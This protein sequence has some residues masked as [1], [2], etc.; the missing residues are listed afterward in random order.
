MHHRAQVMIMMERARLGDH[1]EGD[2]LSWE[3]KAF[4]WV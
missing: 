1:I 4:G 2:L 3:A